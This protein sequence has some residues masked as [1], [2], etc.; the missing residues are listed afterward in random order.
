MLIQLSK[1]TQQEIEQ[2]AG[3]SSGY[4]SQMLNGHIEIKVR[5]LLVV[6]DAIEVRPAELFLQLYPRRRDRASEVLATFKRRSGRFESSLARELAR[7]YGYGIESLE[8]LEDRLE[9]CED[10]L[11]ELDVING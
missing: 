8:D 1:R 7:L 11:S 6:L 5:H 2:R 4:V 10:V 3:F 9:R